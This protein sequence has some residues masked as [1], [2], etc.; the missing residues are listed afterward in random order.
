MYVNFTLHW[1]HEAAI[2][3][4]ICSNFAQVIIYLMC[5]FAMSAM[6]TWAVWGKFCCYFHPQ[7][8]LGTLFVVVGVCELVLDRHCWHFITSEVYL[9]LCSLLC[10]DLLQNI[11]IT[12]SVPSKTI[13]SL[14]FPNTDFIREQAQT[15]RIFRKIDL[16]D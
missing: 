3:R 10:L 9:V 15:A 5:M 6:W 1:D 12:T 7:K 8:C 14:V 16:G 4:R 11:Y 2:C 13:L